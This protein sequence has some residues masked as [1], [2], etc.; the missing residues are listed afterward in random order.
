MRTPTDTIQDK[1]TYI[2]VALNAQR[3]DEKSEIKTEVKSFTYNPKDGALAS[4][5]AWIL[6]KANWKCTSS[7]N[8]EVKTSSIFCFSNMM[9]GNK[10]INNISLKL[11]IKDIFK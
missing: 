5:M 11:K 6:F 1:F 2:L 4:I 8:R 9:Q 7:W 10:K 3:A